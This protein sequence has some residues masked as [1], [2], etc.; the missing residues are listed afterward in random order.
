[1][2]N[3][4]QRSRR[5]KGF[6][7]GAG[8]TENSSKDSGYTGGTTAS[9]TVLRAK[10]LE[11]EAEREREKQREREIRAFREFSTKLSVSGPAQVGAPGV[12]GGKQQSQPIGMPQGTGGPGAANGNNRRSRNPSFG[13][14]AQQEAAYK[15]GAPGHFNVQ[16]SGLAPLGGPNGGPTDPLFMPPISGIAGLQPLPLHGNL[17]NANALN[18]ADALLNAQ[19]GSRKTPRSLALMMPPLS[20]SSL[21]PQGGAIAQPPTSMMTSTHLANQGLRSRGGARPQ[22]IQPIPIGASQGPGPQRTPPG[23]GLGVG[24]PQGVSNSGNGVS[25]FSPRFAAV[26][27]L[28]AHGTHVGQLPQILPGGVNI[29]SFNAPMGPGASLYGHHLPHQQQPNGGAI[30]YEQQFLAHNNAL[31]EQMNAMPGGGGAMDLRGYV[32]QPNGGGNNAFHNGLSGM[33]NH[34]PHRIQVRRH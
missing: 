20:D 9:N 22:Q 19:Q 32:P 31:R 7:E 33:S 16:N 25:G 28:H 1:M 2:P 13:P 12:L 4:R 15:A 17:N 27:P 10:E 34:N 26:P 8:E 18:A 5:E 11:R 21:Q 14:D 30:S 29:A 24:A 6:G 23:L 3:S